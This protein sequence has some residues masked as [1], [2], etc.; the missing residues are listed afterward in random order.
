MKTR[1]MIDIISIFYIVIFFQVS[2]G[3]DSKILQKNIFSLPDDKRTSSDTY[4]KE[5]IDIYKE[6]ILPNMEVNLENP[7]MVLKVIPIAQFNYPFDEYLFFANGKMLRKEYLRE[8]KLGI[9]WL[10][11]YETQKNNKNLDDV[12][13]NRNRI[14]KIR[15]TLFNYNISE[16]YNSDFLKNI[17][18]KIGD[19][20][21]LE[22]ASNLKIFAENLSIFEKESE[23]LANDYKAKENSQRKIRLT[24][25]GKETDKIPL[26]S[27]YE[28]TLNIKDRK[29]KKRVIKIEEISNEKSIKN[30]VN[31]IKVKEKSND[32]IIE[33]EEIIEITFWILNNKEFY[34]E[35]YLKELIDF[36][37]YM[38]SVYGLEI[39]N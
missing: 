11:T 30:G 23:I 19:L 39:Q 26:S 4:S 20:S 16:V 25:I 13:L 32:E 21:N 15:K 7:I 24:N 17:L 34:N 33:S 5:N 2:F 36:I 3:Y 12:L 9:G 6:S 31:V 10:L 29:E 27:I 22:L 14:L 8:S 37:N 35:D 28:I 38:N 1:H 18:G